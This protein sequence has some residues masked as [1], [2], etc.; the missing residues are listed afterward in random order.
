MP[1]V[2]PIADPA[3][4]FFIVLALI[5]LS[6]FLTERLR[7]PSLVGLI[8]AGALV[9]PTGL[10]LTARGT[11]V[12]HLGQIGLV[13]AFFLLGADV[14]LARL[15]KTR[16]IHL[17]YGALLALIPFA[18]AAPFLLKVLGMKPLASLALGLILASQSLLP[19]QAV[20]KLG[21]GRSRALLAAEG[22][23]TATEV[24]RTL[25]LGALAL[26][27]RRGGGP[28]SWLEGFAI[29]AG[30]S[31]VLG[32]LLPRLAAIFFKR[33]KANDTVEFVFVLAL[34]FLCA[35]AG[36]LA[37]LE[38]FAGAFVA[39]LL[40]GRFFPERSSLERRIRFLGEWIFVPVFL[41]A[42]GMNLSL[43]SLS[44]DWKAAILGLSLTAIVLLS[45]FLGALL[46]KP[47]SGFSWNEVGLAFGL[48]TSQ[49]A[50]AIATAA[51]A[52]G[53]GAIDETA[54]AAAVLAS[55]A[56]S[57]AGPL[58]ARIAGARLA[59]A[60]AQGPSPEREVPE[61]IMVGLSNPARLDNL[62]DL[63]MMFR[64][65][66]SN[67]A[68]IPV[69]IVPESEDNE[70]ELSKA[71]AIL[72]KAIVRG[73]EAGVGIAPVTTLS[74]S[75]AEGMRQTALD[76]GAT[77]IILG[78]SRAPRFS[79]AVFGSVIEQV[80]ES[81]PGNV[82]V[83]RIAKPARDISRLV[84]VLPPLIER[85]PGYAQGLRSL[86]TLL[87]RTGAHLSIYAQKPHGQAA[88]SAAAG[89]RARGQIQ[90]TELESWKD[91]AGAARQANGAQAAFAVFCVRPGGPAWH[92]AVEKLPRLLEEGFA[93]SPLL[94]FYLPEG[95][96]DMAPLGEEEVPVVRDLFAEALE[97][98]RVIPGMGETAIMDGV[99]ELLRKSFGENRK[100]LARLSSQFTDI[101][102]K[103]PIEL[104][105]GIVLLHAHIPEVSEPLVYFGAR[106]EGFRILALETPARILV[107]LCSPEGL[108]PEAHLATLGDIARVFKDGELAGRL[109]EAKTANELGGERE[110]I[111]DE[112]LE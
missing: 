17:G 39:G 40:L 88:R 44:L 106:P 11:I 99:R 55:I 64:R 97:A 98:G 47:L 26:A 30:Y 33:A 20:Q 107:L 34:A 94:L 16:A 62:L 93:A 31:L 104:E 36:R 71:E 92:P 65:R 29:F 112:D 82:V 84:L 91:V 35:Y 32:L 77:T 46:L 1:F 89:I 54:L 57:L 22:A 53:V 2:L 75:V 111:L 76:K 85:H 63:A 56:T 48:T 103:A 90:V 43:R 81:C 96:L 8:V 105:P 109:L 45:K 58:I 5:L 4:I 60:E 38:P 110:R 87:A 7:L 102:Q 59:L 83:A 79:R 80:L 10:G 66:T 27:A 6:H 21:L 9:G 14:D 73:N 69:A 78:W 42:L 49:A 74:V 67:E 37:G 23:T 68:I 52:F 12:E 18:L 41:I 3:G 70:V 72:A 108:P 101:A 86:G 24:L 95:P 50:S 28:L 15:R 100:L 25:A 19:L 61:R 51:V 13:Y